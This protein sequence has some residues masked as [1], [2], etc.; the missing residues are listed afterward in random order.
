VRFLRPDL[1]VYLGQLARQ[2]GIARARLFERAAMLLFLRKRL[3]SCSTG[4]ALKGGH[5]M[6]L[7]LQGLS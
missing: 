7:L 5:S 6:P 3:L 2:R 1:T 4:S